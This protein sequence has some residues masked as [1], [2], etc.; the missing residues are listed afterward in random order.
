MLTPGSTSSP[1][2][3]YP[4][5]HPQYTHA[6]EAPDGSYAV[7]MGSYPPMEEPMKMGQYTPE[8]PEAV[9]H[10]KDHYAHY[11]QQASY[12]PPPG[13]PQLLL[14]NAMPT[15]APIVIGK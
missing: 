1:S 2:S 4:Y 9:W 6:H 12:Q 14:A 7:L 10:Q 8:S 3:S 15:N 11:G 5:Q 13:Q